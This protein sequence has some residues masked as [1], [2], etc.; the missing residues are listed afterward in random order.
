MFP[1]SDVLPGQN[2]DL[3]SYQLP[4]STVVQTAYGIDTPRRSNDKTLGPEWDDVYDFVGTGFLSSVNNSIE[5]LSWGY[6]TLGV[7]YLVLYETP[8]AATGAPADIDIESRSDTGPTKATLSK[9]FDALLALN[10]PEITQLV[11]QTVQLVQNGAR[12]NLGPVVCDAACV[13]NTNLA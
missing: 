9:L 4:N 2:N 11:H 3:S 8:V 5:V 12:N 10:N 1:Q 13:N 7:P 6:D